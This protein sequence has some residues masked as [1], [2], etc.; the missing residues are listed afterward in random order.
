MI[1]PYDF[2]PV[3]GDNESIQADP[4]DIRNMYMV[5]ADA[6]GRIVWQD[7]PGLK[8][9]GSGSGAAR[10]AHKMAEERYLITGST[11]WK[12][13][14]YGSRTNL[15]SISGTDRAIFADDGTNL[16]IVANNTLYKYNGS[17]LS[18]ISQSVITGIEWVAFF[19]DTF[20][21][22][23]D[24]QKF[25]F[26]D[27]A[28][29][30][31]WNALNFAT[32]N[33]SGDS[34]TRGFVFQGLLYLAGTGSTELW[35]YTGSGN[36]PAARRS[37]SLQ[38]VG[39]AGKYAV[40]KSDTNFYFLGDD[41]RV[42]QG[43][44]ASIR[45]VNTSSI[46]NIINDY[47]YVDDCVISSCV[48]KGQTFIILKFPSAGDCLAYSEINDYWIT[49]S[50]GTD[51]VSR[52]AWLGSEVDYC[53]NKNL[54]T[55]A[56]SG[57]TYEL[58]Y[59]TYT[60]NGAER[61]RILIGNPITGALLG[62]PQ[63]QITSKTLHIPMQTGVGLATGQGSSPVIMCQMSP[64]GGQVYDSESQ[65][66]IGVMGDYAKKVV[67]DHFTT[68][69]EIVPKLMISDPVPLTVYSGGSVDIENAGY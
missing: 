33:Q 50:G 2:S 1:V 34:L 12:E 24:D 44:G 8:L 42:Y 61:L 5:K 27:T 14:E 19:Y 49:L 46:S 56:V 39:I 35:Q 64:S 7:F 29:P 36:P 68:G 20:V 59:N 51:R 22:G 16:L 18:T 41:R 4:A 11:L 6:S 54:V 31:T 57:N 25:A 47:G 52:E 66:S 17:I 9:F 15:G 13:D 37:S 55:D 60:D 67:F 3:I 26:S 69:Y 58:D 45:S 53:Y 32:A 28:D 30:D 38:N 48:L 23:G 62:V 63:N 65:I 10:G 21:I 43:S 40:G